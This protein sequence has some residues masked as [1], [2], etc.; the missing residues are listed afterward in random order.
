MPL[1]GYGL[2]TDIALNSG[3]A[4]QLVE[5]IFYGRKTELQTNDPH[6]QELGVLCLQLLQNALV[7]VNTMML[8]RV[9]LENDRFDQL[10]AE[11]YRA[12]T[13]LFTVNVNPYGDF[14]LDL[15]KPS[16]LQETA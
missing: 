6:I 3:D 5:F 11:D 13:P 2:G 15:E 7:L 4:F 9:L 1:Y 12:L 10:S 8:D 14:N 16:F